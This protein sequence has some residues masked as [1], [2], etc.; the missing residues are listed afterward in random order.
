LVELKIIKNTV[1][2]SSFGPLTQEKDNFI[3]SKEMTEFIRDKE[4]L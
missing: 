1:H 4:L 3:F 2:K